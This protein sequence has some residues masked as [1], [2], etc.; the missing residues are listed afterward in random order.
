MKS[1][2]LMILFMLFAGAVVAQQLQQ[3]PYWAKD[4]NG[5]EDL[6]LSDQQI[7]ADSQKALS[8]D[9]DAAKELGG[10]YLMAVGDRTKAEYWYRIAAENG[11]PGAQRSY[12]NLLLQDPKESRVRAIF[13]L[14]RAADG[15]DYLAKVTLEKLQHQSGGD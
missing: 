8:G 2:S 12:A 15:G 11:D 6:L 3:Q 10:Y 13:W 4:R 5:N 9:G 14:Q 1:F 7:A